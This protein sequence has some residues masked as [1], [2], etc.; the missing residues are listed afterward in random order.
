MIFDPLTFQFYSR[1]PFS[2]FKVT[3][4][5]V[6]RLLH[7]A[8]K[9]LLKHYELFDIYDHGEEK[10]LAF[11]LSFGADNRTLSSEEMDTTFDRIVALAKERFEA[12]L[13]D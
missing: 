6:E 4:S 10:S 13:R 7:E 2:K 3:V 8:G 9:P 1:S 12:R 11:H 5:E